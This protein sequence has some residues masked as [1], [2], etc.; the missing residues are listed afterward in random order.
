[1]ASAA[2]TEV[3][4]LHSF[5]YPSSSCDYLFQGREGY[6]ERHLEFLDTQHLIVKFPIPK[7][8]VCKSTG[9]PWPADFRSVVLDIS[10]N[11]VSSQEWSRPE[12]FNM[13]AGPDGRIL[14]ITSDSI[15]LLDQSFHPLQSI[16][17]PEKD[18]PR[19]MA[20]SPL[21]VQL[22]PSR[23]GFVAIFPEFI[24]RG[25]SGFSAY[26]DGPVP[27]HQTVTQ[28]T[29]DVIVG[30][31]VLVPAS[32]LRGVVADSRLVKLGTKLYACSKA[33]WI[34]IPATEHPVCLTSDFH[35]VETN[36]EGDQTLIANLGDLAPGWNSGFRY[37]LTDANAKRILLDSHGVRFPLT[38]ASGFGY[39]RK[40]A[41]YDLRS[42]EE[43][44][45][46]QFSINSDVAVSP[47]G[48]LLAVR[49][50]AHIKI[51]HLR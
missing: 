41:V 43:V 10:G 47:D 21:S 36:S 46:G 31:G 11:L 30:D 24:G 50:K 28:D 45:R 51:Y 42:K 22:S 18:F 38:D 26:F 23:H 19:S 15:R 5:G 6:P 49:E 20:P 13:Q 35:L 34:A 27:M 40:V 14:E 32:G 44:F 39:Y 29:D 12:I 3:I 48:K 9:S 37:Q 2:P 33:F 1:M 25:F 16:E 17:L 4:D 7:G 8:G